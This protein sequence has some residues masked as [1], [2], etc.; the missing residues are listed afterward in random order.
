MSKLLV[1]IDYNESNIDLNPRM[2]MEALLK[3]FD[4]QGFAVM[5]VDGV[6]VVVRG[7]LC[8]QCDSELDAYGFC[9]ECGW[10][11]EG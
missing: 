3:V 11:S 4:D 7:L 2:V 1:E 9:P 10:D 5:K 8:E 6:A